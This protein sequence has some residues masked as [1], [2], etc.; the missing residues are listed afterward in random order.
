MLPDRS[1]SAWVEPVRSR[2]IAAVGYDPARRLLLVR[3]TSAETYVY[4]DVPPGLP[5][6]FLAAGS[7]GRFF[8]DEVLDRF[9]YRKVEPEP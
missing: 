2:A 3:F 1:S 8:Q 4:A 9:G 7:K 5:E 6:R